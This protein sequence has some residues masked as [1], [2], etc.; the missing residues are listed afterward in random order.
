VAVKAWVWIVVALVGLAV[1]AMIALVGAG[2]Y[3]VASNVD[4][5]PATRES[6]EREFEAARAKFAGQQPLLEIDPS[7]R[8]VE[9]STERTAGPPAQLSSMQVLA[10]D[11]DEDRLV[12][13]TIPFWLLRL[14]SR[15]RIDLGSDELDLERM[16]ITAGDLERYGPG[17]LVD[18]RDRRGVRVLVWVQ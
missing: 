11:P 9:R 15:G 7:G 10:F 16:S 8:A 14:G 12:R 3:M 4:I 1:L 5:K 2:M 6:A 18:H 13:V 17:L